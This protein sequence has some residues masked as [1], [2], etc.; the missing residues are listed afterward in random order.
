[1]K[2]ETELYNIIHADAFASAFAGMS[3]GHV[4]S[5]YRGMTGFYDTAEAVKDHPHRWKKPG[6]YGL[7]S[8]LALLASYAG[9]ARTVGKTEMADLLQ[10]VLGTPE[11]RVQTIRGNDPCVSEFLMLDRTSGDAVYL[12]PGCSP[13]VLCS[14]YSRMLAPKKPSDEQIIRFVTLFTRNSDTV[15]GALF[16]DR[17]VRHQVFA[18]PDAA[19]L[20]AAA[21]ADSLCENMQS[22]LPLCFSNGI[23]PDGVEQAAMHIQAVVSCYTDSGLGPHA[24]KS[25]IAYVDSLMH[26][27]VTRV[28]IDHPL[29]LPFYAIVLALDERYNSGSLPGSA[30]VSGGETGLAAALACQLLPDGV[31]LAESYPFLADDLV[32]KKQIQKIVPRIASGRCTMDEMTLFF[33]GEQKLSGKEREERAVL[34]KHARKKAPV[35]RKKDTRR[36]REEQLSKHVVESWTKRDKAR[37]KREQRRNTGED[38]GP[39]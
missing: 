28:T 3:G 18:R 24:E 21:A 30:V 12:H 7:I 19:F 32:N 36:D 25:H 2:I 15:A 17:L 9:A 39:V 37:W 13:L 34:M 22:I 29:I 31:A 20:D 14:L 5:F 27:P 1:M 23:H 8:Q 10:T 26:S 11:E 4:R 33:D 35:R 6:L 16:W 38:D